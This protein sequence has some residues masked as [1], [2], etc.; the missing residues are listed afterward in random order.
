MKATASGS[1]DGRE[2]GFG[3]IQEEEAYRWWLAAVPKAA[4]PNHFGTVT[5]PWAL[6]QHLFHSSE[7]WW[8]F[9]HFR[10]KFSSTGC[11]SRWTYSF[12]IFPHIHTARWS[13]LLCG[14]SHCWNNHIQL[15]HQSYDIQTYCPVNSSLALVDQLCWTTL[16]CFSCFRDLQCFTVF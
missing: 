5:N 3:Q 1:C 8:A 6:R 11:L 16:Y 10:P 13:T 12:K 2:H 14:G 9:Q 4:V 15:A 7:F